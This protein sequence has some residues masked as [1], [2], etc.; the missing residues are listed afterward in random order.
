MNSWMIW[1]ISPLVG[2]LIGFVTN[3]IAIKMLFRPLR[4]KRVLGI[5]VPFTPG[6][7]PRQR[8][9]LAVNIGKMVSRELLTESIVRSRLNTPNFKNLLTSSISTYTGKLAATPLAQLFVPTRENERSDLE[10]TLR[11]MTGRFIASD[12][13]A[14]LLHRV[15]ERAVDRLGER[16]LVDLLG[17]ATGI[18]DS[19][20]KLADRFFSYLSSA[21]AEQRISDALDAF[22]QKNEVDGRPL[23]TYLPDSTSDAIARAA[24]AVYPVIVEAG[25]RFLDKPATRKDL[26]I[27]G[28]VFL[29]DAIMELNA[30][31]RFF[32]SAAQYDRTL[33]ERMPAIIDGFVLRVAQTAKEEDTRQRFVDSVRAATA[34]VLSRPLKA[35]LSS[36]HAEPRNL[37]Q[38]I[39]TRS[40]AFIADPVVRERLISFVARFAENSSAGPLRV[41]LADRFGLSL[42]DVAARLS[43]GAVSFLRSTDAA[44]A[45][46]LFDDFISE[47][48]SWTLGSLLSIDQ[49][50]L[51]RF[52]TLLAERA[53]ELFDERIPS[54]IEGLDVQT[55]VTD[56]IDTLDI[57]RVERIIL[58]VLADQ[59]K[60]INV[61]GAVLGALI[62]AVQ[63]A[64]SGLL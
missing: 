12:S 8:H 44:S 62:G 50:E 17:S 51:R 26:E 22:L 38:T 57:E 14:S 25:L 63:A 36:L 40:I 9:R 24:A 55:M 56:R 41:L 46:S 3:E 39:I 18:K 28:K 1:V 7:I 6:I 29:R 4:E 34:E 64:L 48:G 52:D 42:H 45:A 30:F 54:I 37:L 20:A 19:L 59:L 23:A 27:R 32:V 61:F 33:E 43:E 58:D 10:K 47:R 35:A 13:F 15:I 5:R 53:L 60:W 11:S 21:D 2:A 16:S 49:D 31:Q